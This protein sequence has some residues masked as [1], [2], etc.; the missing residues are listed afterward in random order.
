M[1]KAEKNRILHTAVFPV[2]L[3]E[4]KSWTFEENLLTHL[5]FGVENSQE[6]IAK[7]MNKW[8]IEQIKQE[9]SCQAYMIRHK[10]SYFIFQTH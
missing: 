10:C 7:K 2:T 5:N 4:S 3:D 6:W 8:T 1:S 9:F